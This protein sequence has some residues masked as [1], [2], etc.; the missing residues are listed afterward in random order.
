[1]DFDYSSGSENDAPAGA[2]VPTGSTAVPTGTGPSAASASNGSGHGKKANDPS[3]AHGVSTQNT[4]TATTTTCTRA[5]PTSSSSSSTTRT[6][7]QH[8]NMTATPTQVTEVTRRRFL[9]RFTKIEDGQFHCNLCAGFTCEKKTQLEVH[10]AVVHKAELLAFAASEA[11]SGAKSASRGE[12]MKLRMGATKEALE[13]EE[14]ER[15]EREMKVEQQAAAGIDAAS[16]SNSTSTG[17]EKNVGVTSTASTRER[18]PRRNTS[19]IQN[20]EEKVDA[21]TQEPKKKFDFS[22][23]AVLG[24]GSSSSGSNK[25]NNSKKTP[26]TSIWAATKQRDEYGAFVETE[27]MRKT[28][29]QRQQIEED[30]ITPEKLA[31]NDKRHGLDNDNIKQNVISSLKSVFVA[32]NLMLLPKMEARCTLC[33]TKCPS[34]DAGKQHV[35]EKH[36]PE[37]H[38]DLEKWQKFVHFWAVQKRSSILGGQTNT[39]CPVCNGHFGRL[40]RHLGKEV[41]ILKDSSHVKFYATM[42]K[43][44]EDAENGFNDF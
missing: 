38:K 36:Q 19:D 33:R 13:R 11:A 15:R 16:L 2:A 8:Q 4:T 35:L 24:G 6:A 39:Q 7:H 28:R 34:M 14:A 32:S 22:L 12:S 30:L 9:T 43:Q 44:E 26:S 40:D 1:M 25:K 23:D 21:G 41:W 20:H 27:Q 3:S 17:V 5:T 10:L 31:E 18:S 42:K 29:I 37:L